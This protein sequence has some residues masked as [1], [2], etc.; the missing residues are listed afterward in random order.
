METAVRAEMIDAP[1][2][3]APADDPARGRHREIVGWIR[4]HGPDGVIIAV[5]SFVALPAG[6]LAPTAGL[7]PSWVA[8]LHLA[9]RDDLVF[10]RDVLFTYGP[11]GFTS[12]PAYLF[13]STWF[14]AMAVTLATTVGLV[15][16]S[17][18]LLVRRLP[19]WAAA[20][21]TAGLATAFRL[22]ASPTV[23][24]E[25]IA[26]LV[27]LGYVTGERSDRRPTAAALALGALAGPMLLFKTTAGI[28]A[29]AVLGTA[30]A[31]RGLLPAGPD[32]PARRIAR[33][34]ALFAG[35]AVVAT[36]LAWLLAGQPLGALPVWLARSGEIVAGYGDAM[37]ADRAGDTGGLLRPAVFAGWLAAGTM[38]GA[39]AGRRRRAAVGAVLALAVFLA[40][41]QTYIRGHIEIFTCLMLTIGVALLVIW[42]VRRG[43]AFT[44]AVVVSLL[45]IAPI[46]PS[47]T[48]DPR[49][50]FTLVPAYT[51]LA[52]DPAFQG[53]WA[54]Q[55]RD[56]MRQD[57][58]V[59]LTPDLLAPAFGH[60]V[61]IS[62]W[63]AATAYAYPELR[64][65]PLPV[66]QDYSV[67]TEPLDR[68]NAAALGAADR[69]E[70]VVRR[71]GLAIDGRVPRWDP[72]AASLELVCR[73][74]EV[75]AG[76]S[77]LLLEA[78]PDRCGQPDV[79]ARGETGL[80]TPLVVPP[81]PGI[82]VGRFSGLGT[83]VGSRLR[84]LL[85][86]GQEL[87]ADTGDGAWHRFLP[88][89]QGS[90]HVLRAPDCA[91]RILD[92]RASDIDAVRFST[93]PARQEGDDRYG[94]EVAV[95]PIDC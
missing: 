77:W 89:T 79:V 51:R 57:M 70:F 46:D 68:L 85:Y 44:A 74:R 80:G 32:H 6:P 17:H 86:R 43:G 23:A 39:W 90:W 54:E 76:G 72:P 14:V 55:N 3:E 12:V 78:A 92:G 30:V 26:V 62:P 56:V 61:H 91:R 37:G 38:V 33:L 88:G 22:V 60:T 83:G 48:L 15:A 75:R 1:E 31:A 87:Y 34:L 20:V 19:R 9:A 8:A 95:I 81:A 36:A 45:S 21:T 94:Y 71:P 69:P 65:R 82:V 49:R 64:W 10:G 16:A 73:Y 50:P 5:V 58:N 63:D 93:D 13:P 52:T 35:A 2:A 41:K 42:G 84:S 24:L 25:A 7:D 11:L 66:F 29:L 40:Y 53:Q 47:A 59:G 4:R 27:A 28:F 18:L 67:Y